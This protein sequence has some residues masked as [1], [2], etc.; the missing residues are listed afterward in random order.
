MS[1]V[2][3]RRIGLDYLVDEVLEITQRGDRGSCPVIDERRI[4]AGKSRVDR[5][6][7]LLQV[8]TPGV[9]V[10]RQPFVGR[11]EATRDCRRY[12]PAAKP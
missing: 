8:N 6:L 10:G 12:T 1:P 2:V 4:L 5:V 7:D 9:P 11:R 3:G